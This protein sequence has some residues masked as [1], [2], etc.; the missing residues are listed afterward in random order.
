MPRGP[1]TR[2]TCDVN[3]VHKPGEDGPGV[4]GQ[5]VGQPLVQ[6]AD[7]GSDSRPLS[8]THLGHLNLPLGVGDGDHAGP[9]LGAGDLHPV[10]HTVPA[11]HRTN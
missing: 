7:G 4:G 11:R 8:A 2:P 5:L 6:L 1:D 3:L 10:H 9:A